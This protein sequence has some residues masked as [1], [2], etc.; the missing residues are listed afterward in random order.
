MRWIERQEEEQNFLSLVDSISPS[1]DVNLIAYMWGAMHVC[2]ASMEIE[3][4]SKSNRKLKI[5]PP[6]KANPA[7]EPGPEGKQEKPKPEMQPEEP[8][9]EEPKVTSSK[10]AEKSQ[11]KTDLKVALFKNP[12]LT[13]DEAAAHVIR[14]G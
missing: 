14:N 8:K 11:W 10:R 1:C 4:A 3:M 12:K 9:P 5:V 7:Q 13:T 6:M 2:I